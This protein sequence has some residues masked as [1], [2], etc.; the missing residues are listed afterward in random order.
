MKREQLEA[1]QDSLINGQC[2]QMVE[3]I[4]EYGLYG[5]FP[6]YQNFLKGYES[7][8]QYFYFADAV[9][10]YHRIKNR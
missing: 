1:I 4:D 6:D 2:K 8:D 10:S 9:I 5:F 7:D 3:Q